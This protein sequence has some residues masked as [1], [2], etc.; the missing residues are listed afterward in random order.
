VNRIARNSAGLTR[1]AWTAG[2]A[3]GAAA[4]HLANLPLWIPVLLCACM[5]WRIAAR[6]LR[7]PLPGTWLIG[8]ITV[9]AC[10][11]VLVEYG[12]INGLVPGTAL[13]VVMVALKFLEAR[14]QRDHIILTVIAYF[15]VFA[16][17]L[18]GGG[19]IKGIYVL[20]FVWI[21]T[22]GLL[23][24]GRVGPLLANGPMA[25]QAGRMLAQAIPIMAVL[26]VLFPRLSS[27]LWSLPGQNDSATTGLS[28]SMSPGDITN[29]GLSDAIAFRAQFDG[30]EPAASELYWRGPVLTKFDGRSWTQR[31]GMRGSVV[32]TIEHVGGMSRYRVLL[33]AG[34]GNWAFALDMPADWSIEGRFRSIGMRSEYQLV[35][36]TP[37]LRND[38][39]S[40]TVTSYSDYRARE[41]LDQDEIDFYRR[42]PAGSNP[43]TRALVDEW[44]DRSLDA[45]EL[46]Q[47]ALRFF[48]AD[49]FYYTLT[50][51][52][53]GEHSVDEFV[54]ETREGFCEH[55][56]SAFAVMMR[57]A[58]LPARVV[59][60]YQ[61][62]ELNG[63][64]DY[65]VIRQSNAHAW[66]EVWF[67]AEGW[68]RVD[69]ISAVA[70]ERIAL[71]STRADFSR[72]STMARRLAAT[73]L[74]RQLAMGWDA[75]NTA[76][77]DW[78][79]GYGPRL[80]RE[81]LERLGFE[82]PSRSE[83]L[84]MS[85]IAAT[86]VALAL[87]LYYGRGL[88]RR[89]PPDA[90][91]R[92]FRRFIRKLER[93]NVPEI[94]TG[95]A[96]SRFARRA[97]ARLPECSESIAAITRAYLA[98]RYEPDGDGATLSRLESLVR[99]FRPDDIRALR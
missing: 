31:D 5:V 23:Q 76:W 37:E 72:E 45:G 28:G 90:A 50:P 88:G 39:L 7:W 34:S 8:A 35:L 16:S 12:T 22:I 10:A 27:P 42:L 95:E 77:N 91:A 36:R 43:R 58:G 60:G 73:N 3:L 25:R 70:P 17:L 64:G 85:A 44:L 78:I 40:Y 98:A 84:L 92:S 19:L 20:V 79:V 57:M 47:T 96:P 29:L 53:L 67:P 82:R 71:G 2:I 69:P 81:L 87:S 18:A 63:F 32:D 13:L 83:L 51:P 49:G 66:T 59:T 94:G 4:P 99:D 68:V 6:L 93:V 61:G 89:G 56:A 54:F 75:V 52:P 74:L 38:R 33:D 46:V 1:L 80:Q 15:L 24:V 48:E 11:S 41:P 65:Y 14:T 30:Q 9:G 26:F 86:L 62:G 55:Y 21:T 97:S